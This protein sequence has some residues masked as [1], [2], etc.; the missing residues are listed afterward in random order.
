MQLAATKELYI[1]KKSYASFLTIYIV[2]KLCLLFLSLISIIPVG[3]KRSF[4][5]FKLIKYYLRS[6]ISQKSQEGLFVLS[7]IVI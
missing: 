4:S 7:A 1:L 3:A 2:Y 5:K 6:T